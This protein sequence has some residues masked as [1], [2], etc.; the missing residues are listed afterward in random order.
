MQFAVELHGINKTYPGSKKKINDNIS[1]SLCRGE[2]LCI[3][4]ENGAGKT[5][6]M[7][8]LNG[9]EMPDAGEIRINGSP[10]V[11]DSPLTAQK[12]GIGMV[13][14]H[15][16]LFPEFTV[17][18]NIVFGKEPL[19]WKVFFSKKKSASL[20]LDI[21]NANGF[22]IKPNLR[23]NAL[24]V[25]EMQQIE[26]CRLL[27]RNSDIIILDEPTSVLTGQET[28]SL[29]GVLKTLANAGKSLF[30]ITHK[31]KE[32]KQISDRIAI[33][34]NGQIEGI[35]KNNEI[36]E[37]TISKI[38][39]G[40]D[41]GHAVFFKKN[42]P[43]SKKGSKPI[44]VF[45]N[46][47]VLKRGQKRPLLNKISFSVHA[48]EVVGF[49]GLSGNGLGVLEAA[50]GGFLH[51]SS[52]IITHNGKDISHMNTRCLRRQGLA[53]VP[54]DRLILGSSAEATVNENIIINRRKEF[55]RMGFLDRGAIQKFSDRLI[56]HYNIKN[57]VGNN[58]V[59]ILSGGN[60]QKLILAREIDRFKDYIVF[61][62][63]TWG[64]DLVSSSFI[65][66]EIILMR[67]KGAAI[68]LIS[69]NLDEILTIADKII[70]MYRGNAAGEFHNNDKKDSIL[71]EKIVRC[72][73]GFSLKEAGQ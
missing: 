51:P 22:S 30:L 24:S 7:K 41:H 25:G 32:I 70:V 73:Q 13:H 55:T 64:L 31:V 68:I 2:I 19:K 44:L 72:M 8:V 58:P 42:I 16:L 17:C 66:K 43:F 18:E 46:V 54:A 4:G 59:S 53:Y 63:P 71:S 29:F 21:I 57:A 11:I 50:L 3:A 39:T 35:Y 1:L 48:G 52:G 28:E 56:H 49:T 9:L 14:Q 15:F 45:D 37:Q 34:K 26:I 27:Y 47:S 33:L 20:V 10:V 65:W 5:T 12:L 69:T 62:E 67:Q 40:N 36:E 6:L 38:I 60:L 23:V 61:S